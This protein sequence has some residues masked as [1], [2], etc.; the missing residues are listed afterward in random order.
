[1]L[2]K[3]MSEIDKILEDHQGKKIGFVPTMGYLHEGHLSLIKAAR[4]EN[5]LVI[6]SVFVNPTQFA[7]NEDLESYP[8]DINRDYRLA[9]EAGA[10]IIFNPEVT[11]IYEK[12]G[13]TFTMVEGNM[14]KQLC[15][16]SRPI[17]FKGVT[18]VINILFNI[19]RPHKA[20]FGQKD[21]QQAIIIQ[22]MVR[23]L[24]LKVKIVVCPIVREKDGLAMSSR[25]FYLNEEERN[26]AVILHQSLKLGLE[27]YLLGE[28]SVEKLK[29]IIVKNIE[30]K[31]LARI[32]YVEILDGRT[33]EEISEV[34]KPALAAVAVKFGNTRLIDNI[35]LDESR[36]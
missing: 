30:T 13:A 2:V 32:D 3:K 20:Y 6:V 31:D 17:H 35:I 9:R 24:R 15:G 7:P 14:T 26:Q 36:Y 11:E 19:V 16:R 18:T 8:R 5:D 25:N 21:A 28:T 10:D 33:L 22:K 29:A 4:K 34:S 1:M 12:D 23:D 27:A